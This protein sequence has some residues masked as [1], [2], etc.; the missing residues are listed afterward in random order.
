MPTEIC[1]KSAQTYLLVFD[2]LSGSSFSAAG[3]FD[4]VAAFEGD[5]LVP[6]K[7]DPRPFAAAVRGAAGSFPGAGSLGAAGA[8]FFFLKRLCI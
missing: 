5:F 2:R 3:G 6:L 7:N 1:V 8:T 4:V